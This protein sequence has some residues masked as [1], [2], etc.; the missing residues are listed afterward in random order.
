MNTP[1]NQNKTK[2]IH[3]HLIHCIQAP[4][5]P[6]DT[7]PTTNTQ[8]TT[9]SRRSVGY[10]FTSS[11]DEYTHFNR[12]DIVQS[13]MYLQ[14]LKKRKL[15]SPSSIPN[16]TIAHA[17]LYH[18]QTLNNHLLHR[19]NISTDIRQAIRDVS[20]RIVYTNNSVLE[21]RTHLMYTECRNMERTANSRVFSSSSRIE[22]LTNNRSVKPLEILLGMS[23]DFW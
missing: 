14:R 4:T 19:N 11:T 2:T 5:A 23:N 18:N 13:A 8:L 21:L 16:K 15:S 10:Y 17:E 7:T 12:N 22:V 9:A 1:N 20:T 6:Q 3:I